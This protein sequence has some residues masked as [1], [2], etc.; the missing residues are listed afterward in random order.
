MMQANH[1]SSTGKINTTPR[2]KAF[3]RPESS[4]RAPLRGPLTS[5][6][7]AAARRRNAAEAAAKETAIALSEA[8]WLVHDDL[9]GMSS[10]RDRASRLQAQVEAANARLR[11]ALAALAVAERDVA[12]RPASSL[13]TPRPATAGVMMSARRA[14]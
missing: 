7:V 1:A 4:A 2:Q 11:D 5:S 9:D 14:R 13:G 6:V 10:A 8:A 12:R 3:S